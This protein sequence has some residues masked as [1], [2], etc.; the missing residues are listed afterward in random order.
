MNLVLQKISDSKYWTFSR[1]RPQKGSV[2]FF[3]P[4]LSVF[5]PNTGKYGPEKLRIRTL[6]TQWWCPLKVHAYLNKDT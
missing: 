2:D 1:R 4:Y 3:T 6:F 5:S